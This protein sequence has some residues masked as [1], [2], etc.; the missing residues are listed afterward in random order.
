MIKILLL[1]SRL[2]TYGQR[3]ATLIELL[4]VM[5]LLSIMLVVLTTIFTASVDQQNLS[6]NY[7]AV[8]G[9]GRFI[10]ARLNYDI[11]RATAVTT[12][13]SLGGS[14]ATLVMTISSTT[15]TYALSG[16]NLQFT[17]GTGTDNLNDNTVKVSAL[18]FQKLGNVSGKPT[19]TYSFTVTGLTPGHGVNSA[20]TYTNTVELK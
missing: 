15:Y 1:P 20:Q 19:I 2:R 14:G 9:N 18:N 7:S 16:N 10:M 4:V 11:A 5:G 13:A 12:P 6:R 3:G 8:T 17:D